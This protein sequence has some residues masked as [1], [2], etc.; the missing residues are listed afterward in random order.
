MLTSSRKPD[1]P[2]KYKVVQAHLA[3]L[4]MLQIGYK[5][6]LTSELGLVWFPDESYIRVFIICIITVFL[7]FMFIVPET[8]VQVWF[9]NRRAKWRR[10]E[11]LIDQVV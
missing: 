3:L 2:S 9:S 4:V 11:N 8:R 10:Q 7:H 1:H 6:P 5:N